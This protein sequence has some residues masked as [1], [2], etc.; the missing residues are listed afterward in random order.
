[1]R[2]TPQ[3]PPVSLPS[4]S[5]RGLLTS[6]LVGGAL[7]IGW[8][9]WPRRHAAALATAPGEHALSSHVKLGEDGHVTVILPQ[10]EFGQG[11][12]TLIAQIVADELGADWRTIGVEPAPLSAAYANPA[13]S[14]A[15][16][17]GWLSADALQGSDDRLDLSAIEPALRQSAA[18]ARILLCKAAAARWDASWK[19]CSTENGFVVRGDD[20]LR[21]GELVVEAASESLPSTI[22]LREGGPLLRGERLPRLDVPAKVDGSLTY[23]ADIRLPDMV[24]A[25]IRMGPGPGATLAA[26]NAKA[27]KA[28]PGF[29]GIVSAET[30]I[31]IAA[32]SWWAADRALEAAAPRFAPALANV[33]D[34]SIAAALDAALA[35]SGSRL[36]KQGDPDDAVEAKGAFTQSYRASPAPHFALEPLC[37]TAAL[38]DDGLQLW[39]AT[40]LPEAARKAAAEGAGLSE[41]K[42]YVHALQGGGSFGRRFEC[43][44]AA[45]AARIATELQRPVQ[46]QWP[47][48]ED[49]LQDRMRPPAHARLSAKLGAGGRVEALRVAIAT[50]HALAETKARA[51]GGEAPLDAQQSAAGTSGRQALNGYALPYAIS[52]WAIDHHAPDISWPSGLMR[53]GA[54]GFGCF[55]VES[56]LDEAARS[57]G[58]DSFSIRMSMLAG[59]PRMAMC[60]SRVS[61]RGGWTGGAQGSGQGLACFQ[62]GESRI[63]VFAEAR[64]DETQ[65]VRVSKLAAV[66]D[67]GRMLNPEIALQQIEGSLLHGLA[68]ATAAP[69]K[70]A[71]GS[72]SPVALGPLRLPR[73]ADMPDVSLEIVS[74]AETPGPFGELALPPVAP[75][76]ANA[77]ASASGQRF[78]TLPL[79]A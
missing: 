25:S 58:L 75:A 26:H 2:R 43:E 61:T 12:M 29:A 52:D 69:I 18:A 20:K 8:Q 21:F 30:W 68:L 55:F 19:A 24:F 47:R 45:Q 15:W 74:S 77:I 31:A 46:L 16:H 27:A 42:V 35:E 14:D 73:L 41:D 65:R 40:N 49:M 7:V 78:R 33:S 50:P 4:V 9:V 60:L 63:A 71:K 62:Q 51:I 36:A 76:I 17:E 28:A 53:G 38:G 64:I 23:A 66:A 67:I 6:A 56:F 22:P 3:S 1:M 54:A 70:I 32:N 72:L 57:S 13:L 59:N 5:R 79:G 48:R 37:A 11:T 39:I 34:K 44:V 10:S